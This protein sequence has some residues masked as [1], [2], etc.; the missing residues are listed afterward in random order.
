M[1]DHY[2]I[3]DIS[4]TASQEEIKR[5]YRNLIKVWH[6]DICTKPNAH[7]QSIKIITAHKILSDPNTRRDYDYLRKQHQSARNDRTS[8]GDPAR[9]GRFARAQQEARQQAER[10]ASKSLE[11]LLRE[12]GRY[13]WQGEYS[14]RSQSYS[15]GSRLITGL[16]GI[17]LVALI[18]TTFTGIAAPAT[19][20]LGIVVWQ[21]LSR[22][23][24]FIGIGKLLSSTLMVAV[25][26]LL[27]IIFIYTL[28]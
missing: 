3:L 9:D 13:I 20:P 2:A 4:P 12:A 28:S 7:E 15:F 10:A 26:I 5:A 25:F 18:I 17:V 22:N 1:E 14:V 27:F 6:P 19:I 16:K 24:Q 23:G 8:T 11:D 21:S